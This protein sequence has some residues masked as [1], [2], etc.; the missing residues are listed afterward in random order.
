MHAG[1]VFCSR[2]HTHTFV[3]D[4]HAVHGT[5]ASV[6]SVT[7]CKGVV[8]VFGCRSLSIGAETV[9]ITLKLLGRAPG[10]CPE[11]YYNTT[12]IGPYIYK[13]YLRRGERGNPVKLHVLYRRK[14][15]HTKHTTTVEAHL[16]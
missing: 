14:L 1:S 7:I 13:Y 15:N 9:P 8:V 2:T 5:F 10:N 3:K 6:K 4:A 12:N 11:L 16:A